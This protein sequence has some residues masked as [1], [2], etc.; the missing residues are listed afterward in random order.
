MLISSPKIKIFSYSRKTIAVEAVMQTVPVWLI[1]EL[2]P[3]VVRRGEA[4]LPHGEA[5]AHSPKRQAAR[6]AGAHVLH[7]E[8]DLVLQGTHPRLYQGYPCLAGK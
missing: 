8:V 7:Q 4:A 5:P 2:P 3:A 6:T 1:E